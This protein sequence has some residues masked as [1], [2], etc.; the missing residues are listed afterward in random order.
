MIGLS[1]S[2]EQKKNRSCNSNTNITP[3]ITKQHESVTKTQWKLPKTSYYNMNLTDKKKTH[4][5]SHK[6]KCTQ[7]F[8]E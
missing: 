8:V 2:V 3:Y 4:E 1:L 6:K 5:M 7:T